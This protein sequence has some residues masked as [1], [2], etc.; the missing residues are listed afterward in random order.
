MRLGWKGALAVV[1]V[2]VSQAEVSAESAFP[3]NVIENGLDRLA[4]YDRAS[5]R[6]PVEASQ[7]EG[8]WRRTTENSK[9]T[10][11]QSVYLTTESKAPVMCGRLRDERA[12]LVVRCLEN[13]TALMIST[14]CHL[15]SSDYN[16]YGSVDIRLDAD[17]AFSVDMVE[18]TD[19]TTLGLWSGGRSIPLIKRLIG[20]SKMV[21]RLTPYGESPAIIEFDIAGIGEQLPPLQKACGW[22]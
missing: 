13:K 1:A 6:T 18:S 22:E 3:C 4:C 7:V 12:R 11:Q 10:D 2:V 19:S 14:N 5:G 21:A 20:K 8:H 15:V 9:I 16:D 17:K